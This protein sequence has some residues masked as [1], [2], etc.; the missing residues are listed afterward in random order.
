MRILLRK[1]ALR[2]AQGRARHA[3]SLAGAARDRGDW[4]SAAEAYAEVVRVLPDHAGYWGQLGN[5]LKESRRFAEAEAAYVQCQ[6]LAPGTADTWVQ[7]GHLYKLQT[8][9]RDA[10]NAYFQALRCD[11]NCLPAL[12]ELQGLL[13]SA[14]DTVLTHPDLATLAPSPDPAFT[15]VV[16][17][18]PMDVVLDVSDLLAFLGRFQRPTGIQR[19][20]LSLIGAWLNVPPQEAD[21][22]FAFLDAG[23]GEWRSVR[24][25]QL[26]AA[27]EG[28]VGRDSEGG[29][30]HGRRMLRLLAAVLRAPPVV[31]DR[32]SV[33][34]NLGS[35]VGIPNYH[36]HIRNAQVRFGVRYIQFVHDCIPLVMPDLFDAEH[37]AE[38]LDAMAQTLHIA[39][40]I[41]VN[42]LATG[43][44]LREI[45]GRMALDL[46]QTQVIRLDG[47]LRSDDRS[48]PPESPG[49]KDLVDSREP[50]VLFVSTI[51]PRKNHLLVLETW[52]RLVG[53]RSAAAVPRLV[54]V[55]RWGWKYEAVRI[56]LEQNKDVAQRVR[57]FTSVSDADLSALYR[58]CSFVV[59]PSLYEGWGLPVAEALEHGKLPLVS[60]S[61]SLTESGG[62]F[63]E[64]FDLQPPG[65]FAARVSRLID[66]PAYVRQREEVIQKEYVPRSWSAIGS[67]ILSAVA[68]VA[69]RAGGGLPELRPGIVYSLAREARREVV[70]GHVSGHPFRFGKWTAVTGT[71]SGLS[72]AGAGELRLRLPPVAGAPALRLNARAARMPVGTS[73]W[74]EV[75]VDG[76]TAW[77]GDLRAGEERWI[78]VALPMGGNGA[79]RIGFR[80][81]APTAGGNPSGEDPTQVEICAFASIS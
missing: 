70:A 59:Y 38:F 24:H 57:M 46:P 5:M 76:S 30:E 58:C 47:Q 8:R 13:I 36:L 63:A 23:T 54:C 34:L 12:Q 32:D 6:K 45:S 16:R 53:E 64:Y 1:V 7:F 77:K 65:D 44:D 72:S 9:M 80:V 17:S 50:F 26:K 10:A 43:R 69:P 39:D 51:E 60:R 29:I 42:S 68:T 71:G 33:L 37:V 2:W 4:R 35:P 28:A 75:D 18:G 61:S 56:F 78:Q 62:R 40:G 73:A 79:V 11:P 55:G 41:L 66:A 3:I 27:C 14:P 21:L 81:A 31:L 15:P 52:R 48:P 22:R 49:V 74:L 20:G 19:V 67:Q 25:D